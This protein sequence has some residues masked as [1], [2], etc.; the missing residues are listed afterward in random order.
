M[1]DHFYHPPNISPEMLEEQRRFNEVFDAI[2]GD[3]CGAQ[4]LKRKREPGDETAAG[5]EAAREAAYR[6]RCELWRK[7]I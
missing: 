5:I 4:A 2:V 7:A 3:M 6:K 1:S